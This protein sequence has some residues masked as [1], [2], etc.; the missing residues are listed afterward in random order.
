ER[1]RFR[2]GLRTELARERLAARV[3]L[4]HRATPSSRRGVARHQSTMERFVER[5]ERDE[6][7]ERFDRAVDV[8]RRL[9]QL[10]ARTEEPPMQ[11]GE[12]FARL[13]RP[14]LVDIVGE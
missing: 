1:E 5:V 2:L 4:S 6:R 9:A 11:G 10:G 3:K 13:D 8:A 12:P 14:R 7:A